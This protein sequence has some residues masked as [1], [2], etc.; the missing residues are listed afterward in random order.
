MSQARED[1]SL[2]SEWGHEPWIREIHPRKSAGSA[3]HIF[4][5]RNENVE[6]KK[7]LLLFHDR[8]SFGYL[9]QADP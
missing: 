3:G 6:L 2:G 8:F 7:Y 4:L 5:L 1:T 9:H